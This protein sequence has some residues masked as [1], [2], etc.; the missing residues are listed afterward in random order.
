[1]DVDSKFEF[2]IVFG[3]GLPNLRLSCQG[4]LTVAEL[5]EIV[6][7]KAGLATCKLIFPGKPVDLSTAISSIKG[8]REGR[9]QKLKAIGTAAKAI[10]AFS[11]TDAV[12]S[13]STARVSFLPTLCHSLLTLS[14]K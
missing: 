10:K 13:S 9:V 5:C 12:G 4:R 7:K 2:D 6:Q 8:L 1:M 14:S 3:G 11:S